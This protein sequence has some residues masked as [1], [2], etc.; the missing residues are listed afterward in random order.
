[1]NRDSGA[2]EKIV[3]REFRIPVQEKDD[4]RMRINEKEYAV[5][6]LASRGVQI[7]YGSKD[8][9]EPHADL[10]HAELVI[11]ERRIGVRAR[12]MYTTKFDPEHFACGF[13]FYELGEGDLDFLREFIS[14]K[15]GNLFPDT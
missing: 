13:Y 8:E 10:G 6:N 11:K 1:M 7:V 3:R 12:V 5:T 15:R 14:Q 4:I 2:E 9:F